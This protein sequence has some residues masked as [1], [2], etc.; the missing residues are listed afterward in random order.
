MHKFDDDK[1]RQIKLQF[2]NIHQKVAPTQAV[3][4]GL[5]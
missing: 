4:Y 2:A 5:D 1:Q 3:R